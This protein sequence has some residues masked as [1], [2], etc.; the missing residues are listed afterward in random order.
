MTNHEKDPL[1]PNKRDG[2]YRN[3]AFLARGPKKTMMA[4]KSPIV[5]FGFVV[6]LAITLGGGL[7]TAAMY[8]GHKP[9]SQG[10]VS[11]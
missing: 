11:N 3:H 6:C 7:L 9:A 10:D 1:T 8:L 4:I 5:A 2:D